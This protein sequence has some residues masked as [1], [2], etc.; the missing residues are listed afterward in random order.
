MKRIIAGIGCL[1]L[2]LGIT[3]AEVTHQGAPADTVAIEFVVSVPDDT[4]VDAALQLSG[5]H[6]ILGNWSGKGLVLKRTPDGTYAGDAEFKRGLVM[7]YK[8]TQGSWATVEKGETGTEVDNRRVAADVD[9]TVEIKVASWAGGETKIAPSLTGNIH[10][11]ER[12]R[13]EILDNER[14]IIVYLPPGYDNE[15]DRR[16]P[17]FYMHDGQ[18]IF[19]AATSFGG[20]EW[21]VDEAAERLIEAGKIEPIIVVGIYNNADRMSEYRPAF[22]DGFG[23][24]DDLGSAYTRFVV[25]EV[26]PF[27]EQAYRADPAREKT[28]VGG[29]SLGGLISLYMARE[30]A[31]VFGRCAA[32]SPSL[33]W[34]DRQLLNELESLDTGWMHGTRF[35]VDMG[36]EE[37]RAV[38]DRPTTL[39][40]EHVRSL[41]ALLEKAGLERGVQ[42]AY[43]EVQGGRHNEAAWAGRIEPILLFLY[44]K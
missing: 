10:K 42:Y 16:Y 17:V 26:K 41:A 9:K 14:T 5:D 38:P 32:V 23:T 18:N 27:I 24:R 37:G 28:G 43:L 39:A 3:S 36:T 2:G 21:Q 20:V 12:F 13:S 34:Q 44:G 11:H 29:S 22:G 30:H 15:P 40:V 25:Q 31:D 8:V 4:P 7:L 19:D 33:G 6:T 35:W 1:L